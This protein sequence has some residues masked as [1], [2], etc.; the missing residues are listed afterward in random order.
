MEAVETYTCERLQ[1][2]R[3]SLFIIALN[4]DTE[5]FTDCGIKLSGTICSFASHYACRKLI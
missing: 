3:F 4:I 5:L 2:F 1:I